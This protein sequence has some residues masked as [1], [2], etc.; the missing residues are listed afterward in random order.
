[1]ARRD[2]LRRCEREPESFPHVDARLDQTG[3]IANRRGYDN[4]AE[5]AD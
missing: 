2:E 1:M 3:D 5:I 4:G